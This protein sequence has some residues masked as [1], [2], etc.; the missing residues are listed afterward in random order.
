MVNR[1]ESAAIRRSLVN[2]AKAVFLR[3]NGTETRLKLFKNIIAKQVS[4][5]LRHNYF[6]RDFRNK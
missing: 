2:F 4:K 1:L 6:L 5:N 3:I